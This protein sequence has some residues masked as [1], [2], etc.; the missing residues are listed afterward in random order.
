MCH[1]LRQGGSTVNQKK[2]CTHQQQECIDKSVAKLYSHFHETLHERDRVRD[3]NADRDRERNTDRRGKTHTS[4]SLLEI[5]LGGDDRY[6]G[7][8]HRD[9]GYN[10]R[11]PPDRHYD[12][13]LT[14]SR[15][16]LDLDRDEEVE[17]RYLSTERECSTVTER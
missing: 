5:H 12:L 1:N 11:P 3:F 4:E 6:D 8:R 10:R 16:L 7:E 13:S 15:A 9:G 2:V 14:P 17:I